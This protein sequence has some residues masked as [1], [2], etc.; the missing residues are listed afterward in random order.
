MW[1][2]SLRAVPENIK[3]SEHF[4]KLPLDFQKQYGV[5]FREV[6]STILAEL[7][8]TRWLSASDI[9]RQWSENQQSLRE[10]IRL[11]SISKSYLGMIQE[12]LDLITREFSDKSQRYTYTMCYLQAW[13]EYILA[14]QEKVKK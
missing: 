11:Y 1:I 5:S 4:N 6:R 9:D 12:G 3:F 8:S 14:L 7:K 13:Y 10:Q 2:E